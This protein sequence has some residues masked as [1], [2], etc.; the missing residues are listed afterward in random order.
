MP[1]IDNRPY[2]EL[3]KMLARIFLNPTVEGGILLDNP[4]DIDTKTPPICPDIQP[5]I[6][7]IEPHYEIKYLPQIIPEIMFLYLLPS[8]TPLEVM[9]LS[10]D[11][12]RINTTE[13]VSESE[14][15]IH[16]LA[17]TTDVDVKQA[18]PVN[19]PVIQGEIPRK[20]KLK[21]KGVSRLELVSAYN[22]KKGWQPIK[23]ELRV[24]IGAA[25]RIPMRLCP[26]N[27]RRIDKK[28]LVKYWNALLDLTPGRNPDDLE[29]LAVFR[30]V[31]I[32]QVRSIEFNPISCRLKMRPKMPSE[33]L[34][35][36]GRYYDIIY[37]RYIPRG[38]I[39]RAVIGS[40]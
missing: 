32:D 3:R 33:R 15:N 10:L 6:P 5:V 19:K 27:S 24:D 34:N 31:V 35:S 25:C 8:S 26:E 2:H 29:L 28:R 9:L 20:P 11:D 21:L 38:S 22:V 23:P 18:F 14:I 36:P 12:A 40:D 17:W 37:G 30:K 16:T 39:I 7:E 4:D 1:E 13:L